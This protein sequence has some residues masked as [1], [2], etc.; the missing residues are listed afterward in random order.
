MFF[1]TP[2]YGVNE[3]ENSVQFTYYWEEYPIEVTDSTITITVIN[4]ITN[5]IGWNGEVIDSYRIAAG[6]QIVEVTEKHDAIDYTF[7]VVGTQTIVLAGIDNGY[8]GGYYGPIM[9]WSIS[10]ASVPEPEPTPEATPTP[11][12]EPTPEVEPTPTPEPQPSPEPAPEPE[13]T[14]VPETP[15]SPEPQP[16]P[17]QP[18]APVEPQPE[19]QPVLPSPEPPI[20]EPTPEPE[21]EI[22]PTPE[23]PAPE[24]PESPQEPE[25]PVEVPEV[26]PEPIEPS[27][28][29]P[30]PAERD[31]SEA[32][33]V[34]PSS[35][36]EQQV[37]ELIELALEVFKTAEQGS[38]EYEA[39]LEALAIAAQSDDIE[40]PAELAAIP[41]LGD[42][43]GAVLEVF[44]DLGNVGADMSPQVRET[45]EEVI[46]AAVIVGQVALTATTAATTAASITRK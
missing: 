29:S 34:D 24:A 14:P 23:N 25:Q 10:P 18:V 9:F 1:V 26:L 4:N 8:W 33:N 3:G 15:S 11:S 31:I 30:G 35:L 39:A 13:T 37:E 28:P 12:P 42:V 6:D 32:I 17:S 22:N 21:P 7:T 45:S 20:V 40:L 27:E 36:T 41:L 2:A 43:A 16:Q 5:K 19:P 44:N 46:I 38:P